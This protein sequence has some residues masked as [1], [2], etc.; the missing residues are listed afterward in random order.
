MD[1]IN[2]KNMEK[3]KVSII[4]RPL[5][6]SLI[7]T[8]IM[9]II[10]ILIL[11]FFIKYFEGYEY[12]L[13]I[14]ILGV[15]MISY[16]I[17]DVAVNSNKK[18]SIVGIIVTFLYYFVATIIFSIVLYSYDIIDYKKN[19]YDTKISLIQGSNIFLENMIKNMNFRNEVILS[20]YTGVILILFLTFISFMIYYYK[21]GYDPILFAYKKEK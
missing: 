19:T 5:I 17:L 20:E 14:L 13:A 12:V 16:M 8:I 1:S 3:R 18:P 9:T 6:Y 11:P 7:S 10:S 2:E 4:K 15:T 21:K